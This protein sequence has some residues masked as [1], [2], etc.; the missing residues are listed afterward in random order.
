MAPTSSSNSIAPVRHLLVDLDGTLLGNRAL[1]LSV[2]FSVRTIALLKRHIGWKKA[3]RTLLEVK[4]EFESP[5]R[6]RKNDVRVIEK[7]AERMGIEVEAGRKMIRESLS[8]VFPSLKRHFYPV[9]GSREFLDWAKDRYPLTL[10][11][12]PVWPIEITKLRVE[13]AGIDPSIFGMITYANTMGACKPEP[14]YYE[15]VLEQRGLKAEDCLL[16][17]DD[18]KMDLP[19]TRVGIRVFIV[20]EYKQLTNLNH[21]GAKADAWRGNYKQLKKMLESAKE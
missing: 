11:T 19:A 21:K 9:P 10:A 20:G 5:S 3:V 12:N 15:E 7:F 1:P 2:D 13:W 6:T 18:T 4:R 17:G 16:I 14:Q 8:T